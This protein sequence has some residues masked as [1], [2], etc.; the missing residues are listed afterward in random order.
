MLDLP[1][2]CKLA[3][4]WA[5][6]FKS[7]MWRYSSMMAFDFLLTS[8]SVMAGFEREEGGGGVG[9]LSRL[10]TEKE[11]KK[12]NIIPLTSGIKFLCV[13]LIS[14]SSKAS[15]YHYI[16]VKS[17]L[18]VL[19][20]WDL[21]LEPYPGFLDL[22][23]LG[24]GFLYPDFLGP[25]SP[26]PGRRSCWPRDAQAQLKPG[27]LRPSRHAPATLCWNFSC[28]FGSG[29]PCHR[30]LPVLHRDQIDQSD[31]CRDHPCLCR[32]RAHGWSLTYRL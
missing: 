31:P 28:W 13:E 24:L 25:C 22:G 2:T 23:F 32:H 8:S 7:F 12:L 1:I 27:C 21:C 16:Y 19:H 15:F 29:C 20:L 10:T 30:G 14:L 5:R 17:L 18:Q 3:W 26:C 4:C 11:K 6:T 9:A